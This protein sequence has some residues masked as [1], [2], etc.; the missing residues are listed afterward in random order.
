MNTKRRLLLFI[1]PCLFAVWFLSCTENPFDDNKVISNNSLSG[2]VELNNNSDPEGVYVWFKVLNVSTRTDSNGFFILY[3]PS[4]AKQTCGGLSCIYEVYFYVANYQLHSVQIAISNGSV[5][6][7][8]QAINNNGEL[9]QTVK[10]L[11]ILNIT[12]SFSE[13]QVSEDNVITF[14]A[15]FDVQAP[16]EPVTVKADFS[17]PS[18]AG[19]PQYMTA[20]LLD[21]DKKFV[22]LLF[23]EDRG[24]RTDA[25]QVG[26]LPVPLL[27]VII[28][29]R[30][31]EIP[32]GQ[33]KILP[34]LAI[35]QENMPSGLIESIGENVQKF[36]SDFLKIPLKVT[37][38]IVQI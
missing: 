9:K 8:E 22:K 34:F 21:S 3:L 2:R 12:A 36:N 13:P 27:P 38:N 33:Y 14:F 35:Q 32:S 7:A 15:F 10:L 23:R 1:F 16:K 30:P 6:Y 11:E 24:F 37:N 4:P 29:I 5:Q 25:I 31:G 18:F 28:V 20:L 17:S 26:S 19:D